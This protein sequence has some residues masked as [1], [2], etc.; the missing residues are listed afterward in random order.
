[1]AREIK[2]ILEGIDNVKLSEF[3][4]KAAS[5]ADAA[6]VKA[7]ASEFGVELADDEAGGIFAEFQ[8]RASEEIAIDELDNVAGGCNDDD[9][10][11]CPTYG[12][13]PGRCVTYH[14]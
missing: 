2:E 14:C 12:P 1:M 9:V 5:A 8:R 6:E 11:P 7:I 10:E 13:D 3:S 4:A